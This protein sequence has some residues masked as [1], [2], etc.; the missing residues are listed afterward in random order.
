MDAAA[1]RRA[2]RDRHGRGLR[3]RL[4]PPEVPIAASRAQRFD[5]LVVE[6]VTKLGGILEERLPELDVAVTQVPPEPRADP[7]P[8]GGATVTGATVTG[9]TD[10]SSEVVVLAEVLPADAHRPRP[11]LVVYRRPIEARA[12]DLEELGDLLLEVAL[13]ALADHLGVDP[14]ELDPPRD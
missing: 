6:A 13:E 14:D 5:E 12:T 4:A 10:G 1:R 3:G 7:D 11:C 9:A 2:A 8:V